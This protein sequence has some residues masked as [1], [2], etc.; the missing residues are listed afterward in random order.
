MSES[1][2][3]IR[4]VFE[5]DLP[6]IAELFSRHNYG[7][8]HVHWLKWKYIDNPDGPARMYAVED[9]EGNVVC[10]QAFMPR[11]FTDAK[12]RT[13]SAVNCVDVFVASEL[14]EK[15]IYLRL[16]EYC[17]QNLISP[18]IS[19]P[20]KV[21]FRFGIRDGY[22]GIISPIN[23]YAFP[24][25]SGRLPVFRSFGFLAP[26]TNYLSKIYAFLW[27]GTHP[28]KLRMERVDRFDKDFQIDPNLIHGIRSASYLNWRFIDNPMRDYYCF[29]F[30]DGDDSIGYCAYLVA[31]ST[32]ELCD[33]IVNRQRRACLRLLV[34][35]LRDEG[36]VSLGFSGIGL[37]LKRLGFLK[38]GQVGQFIGHDLPDGNW[39]VTN[40]DVD[41]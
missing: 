21:S 19:F 12:A 3:P 39:I 30:F 38:R 8:Q 11:R 16:S 1:D 23:R 34:D 32:V 27:L 14:R 22:Y 25:A 40:C 13:F 17:R 15:K 28:K 26:V 10:F 36:M 24:L 6:R 7:P 9:S 29:E 31:D 41:V 5:A 20:N 33:F 35:S 18:R 4:E 2:F 37:N